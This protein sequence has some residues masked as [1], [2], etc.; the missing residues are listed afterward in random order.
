[1]KVRSSPELRQA[2]SGI[3]APVLCSSGA[4]RRGTP[5]RGQSLSSLATPLTSSPSL[6]AWPTL[7]WVVAGRDGPSRSVT[8]DVWWRHWWGRRGRR[9]ETVVR[10]RFAATTTNHDESFFWKSVILIRSITI[11]SGTA[12]VAQQKSK[13]LVTERSWVRI[14]QDAGL[15]LFSFSSVERP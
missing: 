12:V 9:C 13:R 15:F 7:G 11:S 10:W 6:P 4:E 5:A 3:P 1:M 14:S 2:W 8:S